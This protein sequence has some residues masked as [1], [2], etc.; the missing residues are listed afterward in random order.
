MKREGRQEGRKCPEEGGGKGGG[1]D[2]EKERRRGIT[3]W[4]EEG[5]V[6]K[7]GGVLVN[8]FVQLGSKEGRE[9]KG[10]RKRR[11]RI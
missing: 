4:R 6:R 10:V 11:M 8:L 3:K 2:H 7:K 1:S 9:R 5:R